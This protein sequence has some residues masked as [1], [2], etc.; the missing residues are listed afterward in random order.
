MQSQYNTRRIRFVEAT[1]TCEQFIKWGKKGPNQSPFLVCAY[2]A[3]KR[4]NCFITLRLKW[5]AMVHRS[6]RKDI[7]FVGIT[8][9][10]VG[11]GWEMWN[12]NRW[13][14]KRLQLIECCLSFSWYRAVR[15]SLQS[16]EWFFVCVW[17][18]SRGENS[19]KTCRKFLS[20]VF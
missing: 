7:W 2:L 4:Q 16:N 9:T 12:T 17:N 1:E 8:P 6:F 3:N 10:N 18:C 19:H 15:V 13:R 5:R 20:S 11:W 14:K